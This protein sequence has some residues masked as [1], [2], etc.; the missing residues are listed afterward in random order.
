MGNW[1]IEGVIVGIVIL[2][3]TM[4]TYR[5]IILNNKIVALF[6]G[7][8]IFIYSS[9]YIKG[10]YV[11]HDDRYFILNSILIIFYVYSQNIGGFK[12]SIL[13]GMVILSS[14][15]GVFNFAYRYKQYKPLLG[16]VDTENFGIIRTINSPGKIEELKIIGAHIEKCYPN[17]AVYTSNEVYFYLHTGKN[18]LIHDWNFQSMGLVKCDL[19]NINQVKFSNRMNIKGIVFIT[20]SLLNTKK[21]ESKIGG[22]YIYSVK[23]NNYD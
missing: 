17:Y 18:P 7:F 22:Y 5:R 9:F 10:A 4:V 6:T 23:N 11:G 14:I 1:Q 15:Y 2:F 19:N 13:L 8:V 20:D 3:V 12:K 16:S 21:F